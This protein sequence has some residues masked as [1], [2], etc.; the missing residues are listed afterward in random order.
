MLSI[1]YPKETFC[2]KNEF[3]KSFRLIFTTF[4]KIVQPQYCA[5]YIQNKRMS[6]NLFF[7]KENLS[8]VSKDKYLKKLKQ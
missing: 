2:H 6:N 4:I 7:E 1:N 5:K 3:P 8:M